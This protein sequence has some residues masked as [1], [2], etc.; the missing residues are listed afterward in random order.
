MPTYA[1]LEISLR[2]RDEE[3]YEID[4]SYTQPDDDAVIS[5]L[6]QVP[7]LKFD[8]KDLRRY[9]LNNEDYGRTLA[10]QIFGQTEVRAAFNQ[11]RSSAQ[12]QNVPLRV[13]FRIDPGA[14]ELHSLRWEALRDPDD[15]ASTLLTSEQYYFSRYLSS[16]DW[17]PIRPRAKHELKALVVIANPAG[18]DPTQLTP[19]DIDGELARAVT[20]LGQ[21]PMTA[22][23]WPKKSTA[24]ETVKLAGRATLN[25]IQEC[26]REGYD[27]F[28]LVCHGALEEGGVRLWLE[29]DAGN[30][31]VIAGWELIV[32]LKELEY[33]PRLVVLTSCQS[34]GSGDQKHSNDGGALAA[35]GP[36]LAEAGIPAVL[37]MQGNITMKTIEQFMPRFFKTLQEDGQI[38]R[39]MAIAR[40]TVR[41]RPDWWMPVLFMRLKSGQLWYTPGFAPDREGNLDKWPALRDSILDEACTPILGPGLTEFLYGSRRDIARRL[42]EEYRFPLAFHDREDLPQ[43]AQYLAVKQSPKFLPRHVIQDMCHEMLRRHQLQLPPDLRDISLKNLGRSQ[44][45]QTLTQLIGSVGKHYGEMLLAE[46]HKILARLPFRIYITT[47]PGPLLI[48]AL[49][50][51]GKQPRLELCRWKPGLECLPSLETT[52]PDYYPEVRQPLVLHLFGRIQEPDSLVLTED[53]YFDFLIGVTSNKDLIPK[54]VRAALADSALLFLGFQMDDWNFRVL[55]R[56]IMSQPGSGRLSDYAHIAVQVTPEEDRLLAPEQARKF[57]ETYFQ[58]VAN[59]TVYWGN[60][61]DFINEL[62]QA[63]DWEA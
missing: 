5:P 56:S 40:G 24:F 31:A 44:L 50:E 39:A 13:R 58:Q 61:E 1:D 8:L 49:R 59:I 52:E 12:S 22:L 45:I 37:A 29:D 14:V 16:F 17:R 51:V 55:F 32:R 10:R 36:R 11:A 38:D 34:A 35:L 7:A 27:I 62:Y 63:W 54:A 47:D 53:D 33:R 21:M 2:R 20:G 19:V 42:A 3:S 57:L 43:V 48:E 23:A 60:S 25:Q 9:H 28:Y 4:L 41:E 15:E 6:H 26:L 18:L 46:P 30:A